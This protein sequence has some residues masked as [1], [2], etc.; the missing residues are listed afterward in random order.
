M[1]GSVRLCV[2]QRCQVEVS[3]MLFSDYS[4]R[5]IWSI[6]VRIDPWRESKNGIVRVVQIGESCTI[7]NVK[8]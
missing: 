4:V 5:S 3:K 1:I 8:K 7:H 6:S 2:V